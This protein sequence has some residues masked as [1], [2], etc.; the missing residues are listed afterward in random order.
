MPLP[1]GFQLESGSNLPA[2]FQIEKPAPEQGN[3]YTQG[4]VQYSPEGIPLSTSSYGSAPTGYTKDA[5]QAL[6]STVSLPI[7]IATGIAKSPAALV[8]AYNKLIGGG[9]IGD[10]MVN[11][12]NQIE[13][14]TQ[15]QMGDFGSAVNQVGSAVGQAA[16]YMGIG[17]AGMI[18]SFAQRVAQGAGMGALS[19]VLTPEQTGLTPEQ[20]KEDKAQNIGIQSALGAAIP[21]VGGVLKTGYNVGKALVEP[22]YTGGREKIIGRALREYAGNEA[23]KAVANL[24]ASKELVKGS[25]PTVGEAAGVPSLAAAQRAATAVSQEATNTMAARQVAQ[26]EARIQAIESIKPP[27]EAIIELREKA[28]ND[29]YNRAKA[30]KVIATPEIKELLTRPSMEKALERAKNLAK[31]N[32]ENLEFQKELPTMASSI[33]DANGKPLGNIPAIE[34]S[35]LGKAAHYIKMGLDDLTNRPDVHGITGNELSAIKNTK[36]QFLS[37][38]ENQLPMYK[39]ARETYARMSKPIN[40]ADIIEEIGKSANFRGNLTPA[41]LS[42]ALKDNLAKKITGQKNATLENSLAPNQMQTLQNIKQDL[43]NS[44]FAQTAGRGVGSDTIQKLAYG[45]MLNQIN[46]PNLLRRR[47]LAE[48]AGNL[49]AR[50]SDVVYG[51]ANKELANQFAQTLLNPQ[52]AA[53]Y[54]EIAKTIPKGTKMTEKAVKEM[55]RANLAKMLLMQSAGSTAE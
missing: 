41:S 37:A 29:L 19:G 43:L 16:P 5:Q 2:G 36:G 8:Q 53:S 17:T 7:N 52:Q 47:G 25:M 23:E 51:K 33:L 55:E 54:M 44:D 15:A 27:K 18:P 39:Q 45:N 32:G 35:M 22:L 6:T 30:E 40:Q 48:T 31:E 13:K 1:Q 14:G 10:N 24:K 26:N 20:Y 42:N 46:L 4:E 9:N 12:I 49:L 28:T 50:A 11:A 38:I 3:M 34:G 21:V